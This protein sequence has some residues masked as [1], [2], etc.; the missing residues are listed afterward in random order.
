MNALALRVLAAASLALT[1]CITAP[2]A[3]RS[4]VAGKA[5]QGVEEKTIAELQAEMASGRISSERITDA[6]LSRIAAIDRSGPTLQ[7]VLS[8]NPHALA[9]AR[10]LD[11]ERRAGHVRGPLHGVPIL[12]KD[13]IETRELPTT[14]GS[15][16]LKDNQTGR[17]AP[18]AARLRSAGAVILG[19]ANLSEWANIRSTR[20][21]SGWSPMGGLVRNPYALDR[22]ACGSS[23]GSGV[24]VA[25]N[26]A[27]AAIGTETYGSIICP[28]S[29]S[30][31]VGLK[32]TVGLVSR[33]HVVPISRS[34]DTTGPMT[35]TVRDAAILLDIIA[36]SDP[37]DPATAQADERR[38]PYAQALSADALRGKRLGLLRF[39][40]GPHPE[41]EAL[42]DAAVRQL[43]AAG[44]EVVEIEAFEPAERIAEAVG[45][46]LKTEFKSGIADYL[47]TTP[48]SIGVRSLGDLIAFNK[49]EAARE[50]PLFGQEY[51]ELAERT[52]GLDDPGYRRSLAEA[53]RLAGPEGIDRLL[54]DNR[55]HALIGA[56]GGPAWPSDPAGASQSIGGGSSLL[57]AVAGYPHLTVPMGL[58]RGLPV[59]LSFIGSAW[60]EPE[61]LALGYAYEQRTRARARPA[62]LQSIN[63]DPQV[64]IQLEAQ[65]PGGADARRSMTPP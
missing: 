2:A 57:P 6:Y 43:R 10:A 23:A 3:T 32:P 58:V 65:G 15:L 16:A 4:P 25:A 20:S 29:A 21:I 1:G 49:A 44:A 9:D 46:I 13:N 19:K 61:I 63:A 35:R 64:E 18:V 47:A 33:T 5:A 60:S 50:M 38:R 54:R 7:S 42:F 30:G 40:V 27:A 22:S 45:T 52:K 17:D 12:I 48:P 51:F 62:F 26:L 55:L 37:Q 34:M 39:T 28:S 11:A 53:R 36:G 24:A 31:I 56:S 41:V 59:G 14:A 8:I